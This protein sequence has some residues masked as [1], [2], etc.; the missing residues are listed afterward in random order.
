M[1]NSV[2]DGN[3]V[4]FDLETTSL[5]IY[6]AE[7]IEIGAIKVKNW[8]QIDR[9]HSFIKPSMPIPSAATAV[10]GITNDDVKDAPTIEEILPTFVQFIKNENLLGHNIKSYD[11]PILK[12]YVAEYNLTIDNKCFDTLY[13]SR[14]HLPNLAS[15]SLEA[16]CGYYGVEN[17]EAHRA[18]SDCIATAE[19]YKK[20]VENTGGNP[21]KA[22]KKQHIYH[23]K[24]S[25]QTQSLITLKGII[26][27]I[28]CDDVLSEDEV[29]YLKKWLDDNMDLKGNY[30]FDV[31]F[32][33]ISS[34][35]SDGILEEAELDRML[36]SF[37]EFLN[38]VDAKSD[39]SGDICFSAKVVCLS[40]D[41]ES[42]SKSEISEKLTELGAIVNKTVTKAVDYL[43][44]G[45]NGSTA[46]SCGTYGSKVKKALEM[47]SK[48]HHIKILKES[49]A[50]K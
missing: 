9:F 11:L 33:E 19:I 49:E 15:H 22:K 47:Q 40:G 43:I 14:T 35:L 39:C 31:A 37:K 23:T 17:V 27:G 7:I 30:P 34:A 12:R 26:S 42:G 44:V 21:E 32:N 8:K 24:F 29:F 5:S 10:N 45:G 28:T 38:P 46:W 16:L 1:N 4:C 36:E 25:E 50:L 18:L 13:I 20:I 6:G 41:F 2:T 3:F 48:G